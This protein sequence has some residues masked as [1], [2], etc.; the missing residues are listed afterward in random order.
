[1]ACELLKCCQFFND[2]MKELPRTAEHIRSKVC[3]DKYESCVRYRIF[4]EFGGEN[5]PFDLYPND[6]EE[7][8]KAIQCLREKQK[9]Q[10]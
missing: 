7:V 9:L 5:I 2:K 6:T 10:D 4:K 8:K 3:L 1:M